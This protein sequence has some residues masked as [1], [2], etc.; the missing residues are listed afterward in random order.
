MLSGIYTFI[1]NRNIYLSPDFQSSKFQFH[2]QT[3]LINAFQKTRAKVL[4]NFYCRTNDNPAY[5]INLFCLALLH[6]K[7]LCD[8]ASLRLN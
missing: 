6:N 7:D 2:L 8:S 4:M 1:N 5:G 3:V